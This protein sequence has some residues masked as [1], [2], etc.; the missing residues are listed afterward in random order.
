MSVR[1]RAGEVSAA[2]I[3]VDGV[4]GEPGALLTGTGGTVAGIF[5]FVAPAGT[6]AAGGGE[7]GTT[8][9]S[10]RAP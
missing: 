9:G 6:L 1:G 7:V 5:V 3:P 2:A 4:A 8:M 10:H